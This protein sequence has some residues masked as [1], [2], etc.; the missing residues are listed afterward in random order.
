ME[1]FKHSSQIAFCQINIDFIDFSY[2]GIL[3]DIV[4]SQLHLLNA[5]QNFFITTFY[6]FFEKI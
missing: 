3:P 1:L 2:D 5:T 4:W 6:L